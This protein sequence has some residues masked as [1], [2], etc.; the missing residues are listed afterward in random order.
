MTVRL[1]RRIAPANPVAV[2]ASPL[3]RTVETA[4]VIAGRCGLA[5][6]KVAGLVDLDYGAWEGL[7]WE[8]AAAADANAAAVFENDPHAATPPGGEPVASVETRV[9]RTLHQLT[10]GEPGGV[11]VAVTHEIPFRLVMARLLGLPGAE[12]WHLDVPPGSVAQ[13]NADHG[14]LRVADLRDSD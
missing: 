12:M 13:L 10:D 2:Y 14:Q 6:A 8:Q 1:R 4:D 9:M 11:V 5:M 7:T 3:R